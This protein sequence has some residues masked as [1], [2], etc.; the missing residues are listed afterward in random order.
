MF[1]QDFPWI[2]FKIELLKRGITLVSIARHWGISKAC[3][4]H[5]MAGRTHSQVRDRLLR[6]YHDMAGGKFKRLEDY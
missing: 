5:N 1:N 4:S 2:E 6:I 3:L